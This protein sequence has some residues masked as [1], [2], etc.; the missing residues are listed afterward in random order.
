MGGVYVCEHC[1]RAC[2]HCSGSQCSNDA[3]RKAYRRGGE[4]GKDRGGVHAPAPYLEEVLDSL[5]VVAVALPTDPLYFLDL[6]RLAGRLDVLE[7]DV[8]VLAE[9]DHSPQEEV[10]ACIRGR[11]RERGMGNE[12]EMHTLYYIAKDTVPSL[13]MTV[14]SSRHI[15]PTPIREG[16]RS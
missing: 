12:Q 16:G 10:Q 7:V 13:P 9:V 1:T 15:H 5:W 2:E 14:C 11:A 4:G 3:K 6:A 8:W